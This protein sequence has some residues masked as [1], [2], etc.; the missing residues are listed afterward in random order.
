MSMPFF[1]LKLRR[2]GANEYRV[3]PELK[4]LENAG[5][6][7]LTAIVN[8]H[9]HYDHAGGNEGLVSSMVFN[10]QGYF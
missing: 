4:K 9:H 10:R 2:Q 3:L 8:T 6:I 1:I 7:E 5:K